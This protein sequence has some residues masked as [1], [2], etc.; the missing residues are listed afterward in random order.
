MKRIVRKNHIK[1]NTEGNLVRKQR[2]KL[3]KIKHKR[4]SVVIEAKR[5]QRVEVFGPC[6]FCGLEVIPL[7]KFH[8]TNIGYIYLCEKC[9]KQA[10]DIINFNEYPKEEAAQI[11]DN[12]F[13]KNQVTLVGQIESNKRKH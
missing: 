1:N 7:W 11:R 12:S 8:K 13:F 9:K 4:N 10:L 3:K 6:T 2:N 5:S